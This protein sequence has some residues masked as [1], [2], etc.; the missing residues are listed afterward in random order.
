MSLLTK[1]SDKIQ[2][3][4]SKQL[5]DPAAREYA[6]QQKAQAI[7][8]SASQQREQKQKKEEAEAAAKKAAD[9]AKA[10]DLVRRSEFKS[11]RVI[12]NSASQI[13]KIFGSMLLVLV[14][15]YGGHLAANAAIGYRNPFR[16]LSFLYGAIFFFYVIPK[17]WFDAFYLKKV[18]HFY[19]FLPLSTYVPLGNLESLF[20]SPFCYVE[21][22]FS[23]EARKA[24]ESLYAGALKASTLATSTATVVGAVVAANAVVNKSKPKVP[25]PPKIQEISGVPKVPEPLVPEPLVPEPPKIQEISG[26]PKVPEP[27][28]PEP[29]ASKPKDTIVPSP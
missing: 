14:M 23:A 20:L 25:E 5:D 19:T 28:V 9:D 13:L 1:L 27:L 16:I 10:A 29:V 7:Q 26:V 15:L 4:V 2:Y 22:Q 17:S 12:G 18:Q 3:T 21:D 8:D 6:N 24:V 11:N